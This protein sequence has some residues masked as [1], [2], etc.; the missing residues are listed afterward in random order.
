MTL[1]ISWFPSSLC[2]ATSTHHRSALGRS[3]H[4]AAAIV[5]L[6]AIVLP[7]LEKDPLWFSRII[8]EDAT[9]ASSRPWLC[10]SDAIARASGY[11]LRRLRA[12]GPLSRERSRQAVRCRVRVDDYICDATVGHIARP[13]YERCP[14]GPTYWTSDDG[15]LWPEVLDLERG[16]AWCGLPITSTADDSRY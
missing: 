16:L 10:P 15:A 3:L 1:L 2:T 12:R 5:R 8:D 13:V 6:G 7:V 14:E 9:A 11:L 4:R